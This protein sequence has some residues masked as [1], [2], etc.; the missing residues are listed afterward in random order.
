MLRIAPPQPT[1]PPPQDD[2]SQSAPPPEAQGDPEATDV[3]PV[4]DQGADNSDDSKIDPQHAGYMGSESGPFECQ[5]C[6]FFSAP[7]ACMV[8]A[9][10]IDPQGC[11]N[12]FQPGHDQPEQGGD[13]EG[14]EAMQAQAQGAPP[15]TEGA[16]GEQQ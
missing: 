12:N 3:T 10:P 15:P 16:E 2:P 1:P 4:D 7:S 14:Q 9:G 8:V 6:H 13:D 5:H 11:C